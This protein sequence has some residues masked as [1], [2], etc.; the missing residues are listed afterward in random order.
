MSFDA[1]PIVKKAKI[2]FAQGL[3]DLNFPDGSARAD[4]TWDDGTSGSFSWYHDEIT[5]TP[6]DFVGKTM[7]EIWTMHQR[8]DRVF[9]RS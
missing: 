2:S 3:F 7:A 6:K 1:K 8:R 9:L 4:F 5:Y